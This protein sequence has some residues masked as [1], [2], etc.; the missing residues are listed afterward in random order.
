MDS[1]GILWNPLESDG[2]LW[3]PWESY[4][5]IWNPMESYGIQWNP[6]M[7]QTQDQFERCIFDEQVQK[8]T[9]RM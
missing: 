5:S 1:D 4:E 2:I 8:G 3:N 7:G 6:V 9:Q